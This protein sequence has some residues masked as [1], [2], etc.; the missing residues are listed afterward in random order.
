MTPEELGWIVLRI[1][2]AWLFLNAAWACG[3]D[4]A[5]RQWTAD[6]TSILFPRHA[7]LFALGGI[8]TMGLG[9]LFVLLGGWIGRLGGAMIAGFV[10]M[11]AIIHLRQMKRADDLAA[12]L[13]VEKSG[14][15]DE[16]L[17]TLTVSARLG[18]KSSAL[19]NFAIA[20][21]GLFI[22]LAGTGPRFNVIP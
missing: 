5:A 20:A 13:R 3:K 21:V 14:I 12:R 1:G 16:V 22:A 9:G 8:A 17:T 4:A 6:E 11:G 10:V 15:N 18:H 7:M 2:F 19:K